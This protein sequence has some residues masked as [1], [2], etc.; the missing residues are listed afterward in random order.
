MDQSQI[1]NATDLNDISTPIGAIHATTWLLLRN[2]WVD[3]QILFASKTRLD[4]VAKGMAHELL[5]TVNAI[6][7]NKERW[8][9][10]QRNDDGD[11]K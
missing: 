6:V 8:D 4:E 11:A 10:S 7:R 9:E 5:R 2:A 1:G 3:G